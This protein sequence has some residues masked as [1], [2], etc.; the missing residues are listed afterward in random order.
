MGRFGNSTGEIH[1]TPQAPR[2]HAHKY[3]HHNWHAHAHGSGSSDQTQSFSPA[4]CQSSIAL[5]VCL[6]PWNRL[7]ENPCG[8]FRSSSNPNADCCRVGKMPLHA[9][10]KIGHG[11]LHTAP[12]SLRSNSRPLFIRGQFADKTRRGKCRCVAGRAGGRA[13]A[14]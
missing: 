6:I 2:M 11:P 5:N 4:P 9:S 8:V 12:P 1:T 7:F 3:T 10:S 13:D 14:C